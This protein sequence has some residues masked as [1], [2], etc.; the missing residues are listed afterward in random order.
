MPAGSSV[1][2]GE[3]RKMLERKGKACRVQ[4]RSQTSPQA[5]GSA[6]IRNQVPLVLS[7]ALNTWPHHI[8]R[9]KKPPLQSTCIACGSALPGISPITNFMLTA[10]VFCSRQWK[11]L[12]AAVTLRMDGSHQPHT[13]AS[14]GQDQGCIPMARPL[15]L[16]LQHCLRG[17]Y[18]RT[19]RRWLW[20]N[21]VAGLFFPES[22]CRA[23]SPVLL[24]QGEAKAVLCHCLGASRACLALCS[25]F[26]RRRHCWHAQGS[27]SISYNANPTPDI[28]PRGSP[29]LI[30]STE[31]ASSALRVPELM[32]QA[33]SVLFLKAPSPLAESKGNPSSPAPLWCCFTAFL[34]CLKDLL[35]FFFGC[36][37]YCPH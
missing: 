22:T 6:R 10:S 14:E 18:K 25:H 24:C 27:F 37:I 20:G 4:L 21:L 33:G 30:H 16:S 8:R 34:Y 32:Y 2:A 11:P 35:L 23:H 28:H 1:N 13:A 36:R 9:R 31:A 7:P 19:W 17:V 5:L 29:W 12:S 3:G 26:A 15:P